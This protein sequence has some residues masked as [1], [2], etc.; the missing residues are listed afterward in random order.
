M[1]N[2]VFPGNTTVY[3]RQSGSDIQ[4]SEDLTS[5]TNLTFPVTVTNDDTNIGLLKIEFITDITISNNNQYFECGSSHI[6]FG[7][8]SLKNDGTRP[9]ITI[10][11]S[12]YDGFIE[13][14]QEGLSGQEHIYIYNLVINGDGQTTQIGAGWLGKKGYANAATNNYIVNCSSVGELPGGA[15]GSGGIVGAFAAKNGGILY[16]N[17]CSSSGEMGQLDGGIV[18]AYAGQN[19]G[20]VICR[21]CYT[22]GIIGS[23][24]GGI[25]GDYAGD[26]GYA[27]ANKCYT[28]GLIGSNAGGIFGRFAGNAGEAIAEKCYSRGIIGVDGGGI[29][30]I[31]AGSNVGTTTATNCYSSGIISTTGNGIYGTGKVNGSEVNC[32]A[33]DDTWNNT[34]ANT[35]LLGTPSPDVGTTWIARGINQPYELNEIGYTPYQT[36]IIDASSNLI[37]IYEQSVYQGLNSNS[38]VIYDASG[39]V[40]EILQ[41]SG[42]DVSSYNTI[43]MNSTSGVISTTF[44]R[45]LRTKPG[46]YTILL[47]NV[48][49]YNVTQFQ[50]TVTLSPHFYINVRTLNNKLI[51]L[52]CENNYT[53]EQIKT[54]IYNQIG[55]RQ[56]TQALFYK[57]RAMF[58]TQMI[59]FYGVKDNDTL[60][61]GL[62]QPKQRLIF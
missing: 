37:K 46:V 10:D 25:F 19:G 22:T 56:D 4:Y 29:Y 33:A 58:N 44:L 54:Q 26:S 6:Q 31:G 5:W 35:S 52:Y 39:S 8:N 55:M 16:I 3:I 48:G 7:S 40:F 20:S 32:Y 17:G 43:T 45:T 1:S 41:I 15:V 49:S 9:V 59:S 38:A 30:G 11:V 21:E 57:A 53:I 23:F 62:I 28:T 61:I 2:I 13:N 18:G 50:L 14:G 34:T 12:N 60:H 24:A 36:L 47:R 27:E 51:Y 42:G